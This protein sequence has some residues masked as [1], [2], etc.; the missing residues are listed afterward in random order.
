[1]VDKQ[2]DNYT[3]KLFNPTN[4]IIIARRENKSYGLW[5]DYQTKLLNVSE[6]VNRNFYLINSET[7]SWESKYYRNVYINNP[8]DYSE[9]KSDFSIALGTYN[10]FL[11]M[12]SDISSDYAYTYPSNTVYR[13]FA[14]ILLGANDAKFKIPQL[15]SVALNDVDYAIFITFNRDR[16]KD[17]INYQKFQINLSSEGIAL[18]ADRTINI[19]ADT[20]SYD[21]SKDYVYLKSNKLDGYNI[22]APFN[23]NDVIST[24]I[25]NSY[26]GLLYP[27]KGFIVLDYNCIYDKIVS[28]NLVNFF[29]YNKFEGVNA[30][31]SY[32]TTSITASLT[33]GTPIPFGLQTISNT[34]GIPNEGYTISFNAM[35]TVDTNGKLLSVSG[36]NNN[37]VSV[38]A[39]PTIADATETYHEFQLSG[40]IGRL[41]IIC[42]DPAGPETFFKVYNFV[43]S[44]NNYKTLFSSSVSSYTASQELQ[45]IYTLVNSGSMIYGYTSQNEYTNH[46][47]CRINN[48]EYNYSLNPTWYSGSN[49]E[50]RSPFYEEPKTYITSVGLYDGDENTGNLVAVA[51][52]SRPIPKTEDTECVI[53][54]KLDF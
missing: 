38:S 37:Y 10:K 11:M 2:V 13:Q 35:G 33:G 19:I 39:N 41:D 48:Y 46:Y 1:M 20:S 32:T 42:E 23:T 30:T 44:S 51:K 5:S 45:D 21:P 12:D 29:T 9:L 49:K 4:D 14:N 34:I 7:S 50:I 43:A 15:N 22:S 40:S 28:S 31:L 54:V 16:I 3:F 17:G 26:V 6:S 27:S 18:L 47:I 24:N 36:S 52:L 53:S 8:E 25:D